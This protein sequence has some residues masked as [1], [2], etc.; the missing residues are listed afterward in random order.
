MSKILSLYTRHDANMSIASGDFIENYLEFEKIAKKRYFSFSKNEQEFERQFRELACPYF[1]VSDISEIIYNLVDNNQLAVLKDIFPD[2]VSF[3][4]VS[5][6]LS[7]AWSNYLFT[8]PRQDDIMFTVDGGGD[9]NDC[10]KAYSFRGKC[11]EE[12]M[13]VK[14]NLGKPYRLLGLISPELNFPVGDEYDL[15]LPL[16]GKIMSLSSLGKARREY[17]DLV[18]SFYKRFMLESHEENKGVE[19]S[20]SALMTGLGFRGER[21]LPE[22]VSRDILAT[23]Q[24][25]FEKTIK[26]HTY[27]LIEKMSPKRI[28]LAGG[29]ALN[30]TMNSEVRRDLGIEV[31]TSPSPNDCGISLGALKSH[32]FKIHSF[33]TP[34][35]NV[36]PSRKDA[37]SSARHQFNHDWIDIEGLAKFI[38]EGN[39]VG[40]IIGP[41][42]IG[43]RALGNRSYLANPLIK[44]MRDR[45]NS[46]RVKNREP[47]RP[48]APIIPIDKIEEYFDTEQESPYM[49]FAPLIKSK[50]KKDFAQVMHVD[51]SARVQTVSE[52][53]GWI[54]NLVKSVG[55][56]TGREILMNTSFNIKGD[57]LINDYADAFNILSTSDL[58]AIVISENSRPP[59]RFE[60]FSKNKLAQLIR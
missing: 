57:P 14:V 27:S 60:I 35:V 7:H 44:G 2:C 32:N 39:I 33:R 50:Y 59:N 43:P 25:I 19:E 9:L 37:L 21:L 1:K 53:D 54:Y 52:S 34:F 45:I 10:F 36:E 55:S 8:E 5:H 16:S 56:L 22:D 49:T 47:W 23:S 13:D 26:K 12:L 20:F 15:G 41:L 30:V 42:E 4:H 51:G 29:C 31:F 24:Y 40:T 58:D 38:C 28:L 6:H 48:V 11:L 3:T 46:R 17:E 18:S